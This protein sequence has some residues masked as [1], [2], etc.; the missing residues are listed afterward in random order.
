MAIDKAQAQERLFVI[1]VV[2]DR[3]YGL[4]SG[5]TPVAAR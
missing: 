4:P 2:Q 5:L 1:D 3:M